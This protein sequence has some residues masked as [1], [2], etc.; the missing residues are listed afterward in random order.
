MPAKMVMPSMWLIGLA[1]LL[2]VSDGARVVEAVGEGQVLGVVGDGDV[3]V[4]VRLGGF[5][6]F[7]D[8]VLAVGFDGVHVHVALKIFQSDQSG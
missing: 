5:G 3:F 1:N 4:A 8:G 6:H 2:N 7:F